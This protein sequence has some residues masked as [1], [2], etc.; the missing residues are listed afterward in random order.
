M[1]GMAHTD[2]DLSQEKLEDLV[3][4]M[5][6]F[7]RTRKLG[8]EGGMQFIDLDLADPKPQDIVTVRV[9]QAILQ[10]HREYSIVQWPGGL[11]LVKTGAVDALSDAYR[12]INESTNFIVRGGSDKVA[13][14]LGDAPIAVPTGTVTDENAH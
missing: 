5:L 1:P 3:A 10:R 14:L 6:R 4:T 9:I 13:D 8:I 2:S 7:F 11:S 12:K